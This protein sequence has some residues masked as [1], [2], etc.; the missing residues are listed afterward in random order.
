VRER[1]AQRRCTLRRHRGLRV[2]GEEITIEPAD[3]FPPIRDLVV[4]HEDIPGR[5]RKAKLWV[6]P[7]QEDL[8]VTPADIA[9]ISRPRDCILCGIC[10]SVCP[11]LAEGKEFGGPLLFTR[12]YSVSEDPRDRR[13]EERLADVVPYNIQNCVHCGNCNLSCPKG[14]M[15]ERWITLTE[16]KL[17]RRGYMDRR[18]EDFGFLG[19]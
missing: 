14:C 18:G 11:P 3:L 16:G 9:R 4:S 2:T 12:F 6:I 13:G 1:S 7:R 17:V 10:D 19:F 15:P 8:T 5:L